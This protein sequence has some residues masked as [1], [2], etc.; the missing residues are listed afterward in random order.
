MLEDKLLIWRFKR[1]NYV[2][3]AHIYEIEG[4][5]PS[6]ASVFLAHSSWFQRGEQP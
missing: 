2:A 4:H 6:G 3:L 1:G 5:A